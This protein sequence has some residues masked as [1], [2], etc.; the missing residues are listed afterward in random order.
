MALRHWCQW[1]EWLCLCRVFGLLAGCVDRRQLI[2][3]LLGRIENQVGETPC[4]LSY[5]LRTI[6][7]ERTEELKKRRYLPSEMRKVIETSTRLQEK[8]NVFV[9]IFFCCYY[10][11]VPSKHPL[12]IVDARCFC[13]YIRWVRE[14]CCGCG[15]NKS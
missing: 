5:R 11:F 2:L 8:E 7:M 12:W 4:W 10:G 1:L 14:S 6:Y 9:G 13:L 3:P 15:W